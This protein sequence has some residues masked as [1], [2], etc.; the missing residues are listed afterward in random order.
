MF[1]SLPQPGAG[2]AVT[3]VVGNQVI[4]NGGAF[5]LDLV[6][7]PGVD[8]LLVAIDEP[9]QEGFG[10]YEIDLPGSIELPGSI[11]LPGSAGSSQRLVGHLMF[12]LDPTLSPLCLSITAVNQD[13]AA[14]APACHVDVHRPGGQ[15]RAADYPVMG[16]R[17]ASSICMS[18]TPTA[19]R[20][21]TCNGTVESGGTLDLAVFL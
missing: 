14:G 12:D 2:P 18:W 1:A 11:D 16:C 17:S 8:K 4:A 10:Y 5:F 7:D 6:V 20:S 15:R 21:T 19:T 9:D 13:G 3:E